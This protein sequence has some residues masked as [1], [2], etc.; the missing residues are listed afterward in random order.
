MNPHAIITLNRA[1]A[2]RPEY[3]LAA[4]VD[5]TLMSDEHIAIVG[6]NGAGKSLL[7]GM[8]T[9]AHPLLAGGSDAGVVTYDFAPSVLPLVSDNIKTLTFQDAYSTSDGYYYYQLRYNQAELSEQN[10]I[11]LLSSGELR[12]HQIHRLLQLH[13]RVLILENPFIGLDAEA[14]RFLRETLVR[15]TQEEKIQ[16]IGKNNYYFIEETQAK[17]S[18]KNSIMLFNDIN[19]WFI[20]QNKK[21]LLINSLMNFV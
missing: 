1:V 7:V 4:P 12:R 10:D 14:C 11:F 13:P 2:A 6:P 17:V 9:G 8:I 21:L 19:N 18:I 15:L 16:I 5:F 3:R 20:T